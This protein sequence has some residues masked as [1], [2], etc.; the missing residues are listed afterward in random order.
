MSKKKEY[1]PHRLWTPQ[2]DT[3]ISNAMKYQSPCWA[4]IARQLGRSHAALRTRAYRLRLKMQDEA[5]AAR[6]FT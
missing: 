6:E 5:K 3:I 4:E 1:G 2:E